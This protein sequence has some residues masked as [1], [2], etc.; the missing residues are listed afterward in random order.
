[1]WGLH[2]YVAKT[3]GKLEP[4]VIPHPNLLQNI[5][6]WVVAGSD[7]E[8]E[9]AALAEYLQSPEVLERVKAFRLKNHPEQQAWWP[10]N[11]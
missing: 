10:P 8:P 11:P 9:A 3:E 6:V 1:M 2:P 7:V 4:T 5:S